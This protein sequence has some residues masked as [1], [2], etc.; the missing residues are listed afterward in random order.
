MKIFILR[1]HSSNDES[2][3]NNVAA[4]IDA[5]DSTIGTVPLCMSVCPIRYFVAE[6]FAQTC[7]QGSKSL[8]FC[9]GIK[10]AAIND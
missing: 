1:T 7:Y 5:A 9:I 10:G 6:T 8:I 4:S 3:D 2:P